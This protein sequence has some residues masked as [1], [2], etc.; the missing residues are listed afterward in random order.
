MK[1]FYFLISFLFLTAQFAWGQVSITTAGSPY[2][3]NFEVMGSSGST[4]PSGWYVGTAST[5]S[6]T[7]VVVGT[8]TSNSGNNYNFGSSAS[9][10]RALGS[11]A[12]SSTTRNTEGRFT[13]NT[14]NLISSITITY[15]GEQWR[16]GQTASNETG[17]TLY[18]SIDGTNFTAMGPSYNFIP[19][20]VNGTAGALDGN[21]AAN[22]ITGIGGTYA[23]ASSIAN[24]SIFYLRWV[25]IDNSGSDA[26]VAVDDFSITL[27]TASTPTLSLSTSSLS[28]F[29]YIEGSGPS[30]SQSYDLSGQI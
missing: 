14:G 29:D 6:S 10:D 21:V 4:T 5:A 30:A 25:D 12:S 8:G 18:Y 20:I 3:E 7:T 28:G 15:T 2:T 9:S 22:R 19:P 1:K 27:N 13:N 24:G 11:L 16:L 17:L 26:G 23:P